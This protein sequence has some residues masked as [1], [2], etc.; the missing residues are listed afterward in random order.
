MQRKKYINIVEA[1]GFA[2]GLVSVYAYVEN[3][4]KY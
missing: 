1:F 3:G 2:F 4:Y